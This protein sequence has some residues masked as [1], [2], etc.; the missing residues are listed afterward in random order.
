MFD[1]VTIRVS[2]RA[3]SER[4]FETVL[5][6]LGIETSLST[7]SFAVWREFMVTEA[8]AER[9]ITRGL[10]V[11]FV[12]PSREQVDEFW[13]AG[14]DAGHPDDGPPGPRPQYGADYYGAFLTDP[15][16]NS[17]E[18][19]HQGAPRRGEGIV[20][21]LW[22]R[23]ADLAAA[24]AFYR[25]IAP[26]AGLDVRHE[27]PERTGFGTGPSGG[28]FSLVPGPPTQNLHVAFPGDDEAVRR[29]Y[30]DATAAGYRGNGEPGERPRY[31]PGYYA[32]FVLDPD[33]NNIEVVDHHRP[34]L[35]SR[36]V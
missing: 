22:I 12:A 3:V 36:Q 34:E 9:P 23:V 26:G 4:F 33:G 24:T 20:D 27:G 10:H 25:T 21:H 1:H 2:D 5:I 17:V 16:G 30:D 7:S 29:F 18:A 32:A 8:R 15:D 13:R 14:V 35:A 28:S 19:V 6:P 11:A 31:H